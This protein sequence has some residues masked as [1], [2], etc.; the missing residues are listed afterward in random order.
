MC[1]A[2][3]EISSQG[4]SKAPVVKPAYTQQPRVRASMAW[5]SQASL[6]HLGSKTFKARCR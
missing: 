4:E 2:Q 6:G 3:E 5:E 1:V